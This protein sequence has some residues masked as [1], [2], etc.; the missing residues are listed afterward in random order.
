MAHLAIYGNGYLAKYRQARPYEPEQLPARGPRHLRRREADRGG[1]DH[2][3][4]RIK[5]VHIGLG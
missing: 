3:M 4:G 2:V 5:K 1:P